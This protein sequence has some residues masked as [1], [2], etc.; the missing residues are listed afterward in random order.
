MNPQATELH[1]RACEAR[2]YLAQPDRV[3][4][5]ERIAK[6]RGDKAAQM[7]ADDMRAVREG[8]EIA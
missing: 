8:R 2:H 5:L 1:R 7:L 3:A 4:A 6:V